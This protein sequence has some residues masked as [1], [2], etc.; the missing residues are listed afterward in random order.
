MRQLAVFESQQQAQRLAAYLVTQRITAH[1]E[2][3]SG[4][5]GVW[6]RDEDQM[7]AARQSLAHFQENPGDPRY[8]S[9]ESAASEL[10][11]RQEAENAARQ[12]NVVEMRGR[13]K[14]GPGIKRKAP[15]TIGLI[16][17]SG[18]RSTF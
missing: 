3:D 1:A 10:R 13:W 9:V 2:E 18:D 12:K 4:G 11:R 6:V 8:A 17:V 15:L 16:I 7:P 5:F 14:S